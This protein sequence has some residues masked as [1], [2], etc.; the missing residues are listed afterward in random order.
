[1]D[2]SEAVDI[3]F[4]GAVPE[5]KKELI[6]QW[7][8]AA[9]RVRLLPSSG[10][11]LVQ[12]F[13]TIQ[14]SEIALRQIWLVGYAAEQA[15]KAYLAPLT[16]DAMRGLPFDP[17]RWRRDAEQAAEDDRF[18][19]LLDK[20]T[21]LGGVLDVDDFEWPAGIPKPAFGLT[22]EDESQKATFQLVCMAGAYLFAHEVRHALFEGGGDAPR[23][24]GLEEERQC[25]QWALSLMLDQAADYARENG[26]DPALV[27]TKRILGILIAKMTMI[28]VPPRKSWGEGQHPAVR[29]RLQMLLDAISDPVPQWLWPWIAS[30]L[31]ALARR[32][33]LI[34]HPIPLAAGLKSLSY[35]L[36]DR[37]TPL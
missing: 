8:L 9:D 6:S 12:G 29:E 1:M 23:P 26:W 33:G 22:I 5:R 14:V 13:G 32:Y 28:A 15:Y 35:T 24:L 16:R 3:L 11:L 17:V 25:D 34:E 27:R 37:F 30:V 36:C 2:V 20:V 7:G 10:F 21:E 18:D 4:G 19:F 31:A